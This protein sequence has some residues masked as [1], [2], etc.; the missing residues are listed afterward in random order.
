MYPEF[1]SSGLLRLV[2]V[3]SGLLRKGC[4]DTTC[5][6][7]IF[8]RMRYVQYRSFSYTC[9]VG[10]MEGV[11]VLYVWGEYMHKVIWRTRWGSAAVAH[12]WDDYKIAGFRLP[13][14]TNGSRC[15]GNPTELTKKEHAHYLLW[16]RPCL[17]LC[18]KWLFAKRAWLYH[19]K[20][21]IVTN[22][23]SR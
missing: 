6:S 2:D 1:V 4:C 11:S 17:V 18:D 16:H 14:I 13:A 20:R 5:L 9:T 10:V 3:V 8:S 12:E 22:R 15:M 21:L 19:G 23:S 7:K